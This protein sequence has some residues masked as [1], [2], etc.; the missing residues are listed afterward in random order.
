MDLIFVFF[1]SDEGT[2]VRSHESGN[3]WADN[4]AA[5]DKFKGTQ[6]CFVIKGTALHNNFFTEVFGAFE[7]D[8]FVES[9]FAETAANQ[10]KA[11]RPL[12]EVEKEAI[13]DALRVYKG[14]VSR[15][16]R[17]LGISR[18]TLYLKCKKYGVD[19]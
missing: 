8:N 12:S 10:P 2:A 14:N 15:V 7:F 16:S 11:V 3:A 6:N 9:I 13:V 19:I 17:E 4:F 1:L 5:R 18:N